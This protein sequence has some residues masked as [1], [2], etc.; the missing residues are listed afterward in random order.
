M[1]AFES[2][3]GNLSASALNSTNH[4]EMLFMS[5]KRLE[6]LAYVDWLENDKKDMVARIAKITITTIS[7]TS[8]NQEDLNIFDLWAP[9]LFF[10]SIRKR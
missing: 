1:S 9:F 5:V 10:V 3:I 4:F 2:G 6:S 7:S 8:V